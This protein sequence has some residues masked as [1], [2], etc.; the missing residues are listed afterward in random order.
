MEKSILLISIILLSGCAGTQGYV[1]IGGGKRIDSLTDELLRSEQS[2]T[3]NSLTAE[4][5]VGIEKDFNPD[6]NGYCEIYH[7][8]HWTCGTFNDDPELYEMRFKCAVRR[9]FTWPWAK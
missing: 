4:L 7:W 2:Y 5:A 1:D 6:T 8:S 3:C 9:S